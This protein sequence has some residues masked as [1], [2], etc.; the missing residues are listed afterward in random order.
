MTDGK[1]KDYLSITKK[2]LEGAIPSEKN[3]KSWLDHKGQAGHIDQ[4]IMESKY[5]INEIVRI[6]YTE[7]NKNLK[8][9]ESIKNRID[10]HIGHLQNEWNGSVAPHFLNVVEDMNGIVKFDVAFMKPATKKVIKRKTENPSNKIKPQEENLSGQEDF[11]IKFAEKAN[12]IFLNPE[13]QYFWHD[14]VNGVYVRRENGL[15]KKMYAVGTN[16]FRGFYKVD[17]DRPGAAKIF[18]DYFNTNKDEIISA[19]KKVSS[20]EELSILED[21]ICREIKEQ[22]TNIKSEMLISYNKIRKPVDL[23]FEHLISMS[24][25][26]ED[27][28][29]KYIEYLYLPLDSQM[30]QQP[31]IFSEDEL[32]SNRLSRN[33]TYKDVIKK[34]SYKNLQN[35]IRTKSLSIGNRIG[36][37]FY[38]VYFDLL[39]NKRYKRWGTNLFETNP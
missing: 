1:K 6:I 12:Q 16:T 20:F 36:I 13:V 34:E 9:F 32:K 24:K 23:Y 11:W 39:W 7:N 27:I 5:S 38:P 33:S 10:R 25:E 14:I 8:P 17:Q 21:K 19:L 28:R 3:G 31:L 26:T 2:V 4:L 22:L 15:P 30:F 35:I 29:E 18:K 37:K